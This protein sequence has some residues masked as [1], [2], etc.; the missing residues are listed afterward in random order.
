MN[1]IQIDYTSRDAESI[2]KDLVAAINY[3][4]NSNW[5]L[6]D[7]SDL[8]VQL[9]EAFSYMGDMLSYYIDRTANETSL[10]TATKQST[11]LAFADLYGYKPSGPTPALLTVSF[12]NN[13]ATNI[14][15]PIGTQVIAPINQGKYTEVFFE[16]TQ[17]AVGLLPGQTISLT[18]VEGKT[19]NTD[20]PDLI[21]P[22]TNKALPSVLGTS[23]GAAN[24]ELFLPDLNVV[25]TSLTVYIGQGSAFIPWTYVDSLL[26]SGPS[27]LVFTTRYN[28][29]TTTTI[30]FGDGVN[31]AIPSANS[32]I[33]ATYRTSVGAGGNIA[34]GLVSE[35]T[36]IPGNI[37]PQAL[38][39]L[40]ASNTSP[41]AGGTDADTLDQIRT[42]IK[43]AIASKRRAVT[44]TDYQYLASLVPNVG[45][46]SATSQVYSS[47]IIYLQTPNDGSVTPGLVLG[48][49]TTTWN[50]VAANIVSSL[51]DKIPAG[52]TVTVATPTYRA[53]YLALSLT[54]NDAYKQNDVRL[55]VY[56][57]LLGTSGYF[58]YDNN[59]FGKTI[60][61]SGI[62]KT[63]VSIDGVDDVSITK[64][65]TTNASTVGNISL[66]ASEIPYLIPG[67][68][69]ITPTGG[70]V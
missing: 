22:A 51:S 36:F 45:K 17:A 24:Q 53:V 49:P 60:T 43:A 41:A 23:T 20:R 44:L 1:N 4:T 61:V 35:V 46:V 37:N 25:D 7:N 58:N 62:I 21:D 9:L 57:S 3:S 31:G 10:T 19:V 50:S 39:Y 47:V 40:S 27:D 29:D 63:I 14:D 18:T 33:S 5:E 67:N 59:T 26:E 52:T 28:S 65:N 16:T 38:T 2:K 11:L 70:I 56:R 69:T 13:G 42:K 8:G 64:L 30:V 12:T 55:N 6:T 34:S 54:V 68:L 32:I 48:S 66:T 15:I